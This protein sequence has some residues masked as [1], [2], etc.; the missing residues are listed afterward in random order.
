MARWVC[1]LCVIQKGLRGSELAEWPEHPDDAWIAEHLRTAHGV[2]VRD[3]TDDEQQAA[4]LDAV[5]RWVPFE[6]RPRPD[7]DL[8]RISMKIEGAQIAIAAPDADA[9]GRIFAWLIGQLNL[10]R[11]IE[12]ERE[13]E[14]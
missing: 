2:E 6:E 9:S 13:D 4:V 14:R 10:A 3:A 1:K 12:A 7:A 8:A 5:G 11:R